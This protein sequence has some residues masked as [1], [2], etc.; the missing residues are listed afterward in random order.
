MAQVV[1]ALVGES[2]CRQ[3]ALESGCHAIPSSGGP[4]VVVSTRSA[5]T[6]RVPDTGGGV[7]QLSLAGAGPTNG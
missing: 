1:E 7:I 6:S 2:G 5:K 3:H 4:S